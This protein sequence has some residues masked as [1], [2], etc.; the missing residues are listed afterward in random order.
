MKLD[1]L[2]VTSNDGCA[3]LYETFFSGTK[4]CGFVKMN[5]TQ[6]QKT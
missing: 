3:P 5:F 1:L 4:K 2:T 6:N